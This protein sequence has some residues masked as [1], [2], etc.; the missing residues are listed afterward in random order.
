MCSSPFFSRRLVILSLVLSLLA[1]FSG[2]TDDP[3]A[4]FENHDYERARELWLPLA[5][6][7]DPQAQNALGTMYYMGLGLRRNDS[8]AVEWF[9]KAAR[10]G[11]PGAQRNAG[12]MYLDGR[13]VE[14]DFLTAYMWFYA[15]DKQGNDGADT[16][17]E[18]LASKLTP[19]QQIKARRTADKFIINPT[20]DYVPVPETPKARPRVEDYRESS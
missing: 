4:A 17:I 9:E 16:Y 2:E 3:R 7:G 10:Q 19:N 1:G 20:E 15:A 6:A 11:H 12:M 8:K 18:T 13:G 14:Q 5:N